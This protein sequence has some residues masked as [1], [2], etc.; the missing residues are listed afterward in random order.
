LVTKSVTKLQAERITGFYIS[1]QPNVSRSSI[2]FS[3]KS[4]FWSFS[5]L[6]LHIYIQIK[7]IKDMKQVKTAFYL[8]TSKINKKGEAPIYFRLKHKSQT[9]NLSTNIFLKPEDWDRKKLRVKAK[10]FRS[11][12]LNKQLKDLEDKV[13]KI[14]NAKISNDSTVSLENI[15]LILRD[16]GKSAVSLLSLTDYFLKHIQNNRNYSEGRVRHYKSFRNKMVCFL[17]HRYCDSDFKLENLNYEFIMEFES[18]LRSK[19][20]NSVNTTTSNI[21]CLK[22][23]VNTGIK[24][25]WLKADPFKN[26]K[27]KFEPSSRQFLNREELRRIQL[28]NLPESENVSLVRDMFL[29]MAYTGV[30]HGDMRILKESNIIN[31]EG[32]EILDFKRGKTNV[33]SKPPLLPEAKAIIEKYKGSPVCKNKGT[34]LPVPCNKTMNENLKLISEKAHITKNLSCHVGRHTFA[35][36]SLENGVPIETVSKALGHGSIKTTQIYGKIT[37]TKIRKDYSR[38]NGVFSYL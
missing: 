14:V 15:K 1:Y 24:L 16:K 35:T 2:Y 26:Y 7:T 22:A 20:Q 21:R 6:L 19:Y 4:I 30:S 12:N 38:L 8:L 29:F 33:E 13:F 34:L 23:I 10:H 3:L 17:G 5:A 37:D 11:H 18:Y 36:L 28:L 25:G 9:V 31:F 32:H 27:C